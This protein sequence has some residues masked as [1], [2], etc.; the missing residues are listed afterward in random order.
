MLFHA[1][2]IDCTHGLAGPAIGMASSALRRSMLRNAVQAPQRG[3]SS[4]TR[5]R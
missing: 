1:I 2:P 4:A 3:P 5:K